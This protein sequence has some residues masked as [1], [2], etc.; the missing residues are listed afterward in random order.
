[1]IATA[2]LMTSF[3]VL[4]N[5]GHSYKGDYKGEAMPLM[6]VTIPVLPGGFDFTLG[7]L[8]LKP[9][10]SN[11][12]YVAS[13][14]IP[15]AVD[16]ITNISSN[17]ENVHPDYTWG[18]LL[19]LGYIFPGTANDVRVNWQHLHDNG[20][21]D[22]TSFMGPTDGTLAVFPIFSSTV[23]ISFP[24]LAAGDSVSASGEVE[25][26]FDSVDLTFGQYIN[27]G[28]RLQTR[29]FTGL[30]WAR[31]ENELSAFYNVFDAGEVDVAST[32]SAESESTFNGVGP[33]FGVE[34]NYDVGYNIGIAGYFDIALLVGR[35]NLDQDTHV[36]TFDDGA[37]DEQGNTDFDYDSLNVVTP[38]WDARLGANYTYFMNNGAAFKFEIG[39]QVS[40]YVDMI[41]TSTFTPAVPAETINF[42]LNGLYLSGTLKV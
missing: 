13:T 33:I 31:L 12:Q 22:S 23:P 4:A 14:L 38:A 40:K 5:A 9:T 7:G 3:G 26:E 29:L 39:Y 24:T 16:G 19:G 35:I 28:P 10:S 11:T 6:P 36:T 32:F 41:E 1:M 2:C 21:S 25:Y 37:I 20:D 8:Y 18:F 17:I 34:A 42:G 15:P 30:R 27:I